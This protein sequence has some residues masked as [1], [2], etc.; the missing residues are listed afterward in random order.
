MMESVTVASD[1]PELGR[2]ARDILQ[3]SVRHLWHRN[4]QV[5]LYAD[6]GPHMLVEGH[7]AV[8]RDIH[9]KEYIDAAGRLLTSAVGYG[10]AEI[11]DAMA[12]QARRLHFCETAEGH[13]NLPATLL[14]AKLAEIAPGNLDVTFFANSGTEANETA[15]KMAIQCQALRG[16]PLRRKVISRNWSYHGA[17]L[18]SLSVNGIVWERFRHE[19]LAPGGH[20]ITQP[21]CYR[22]ELGL[23]YPACEV[24]CAKML[25]N[26]I[27]MEGPDSVAAFI[28]EPISVPQA[29]KV[30]PPEYWP[31]IRDICSRYDVLLIVDEVI[32]GFGRTGKMFCS[33]HWDLEPDIMTCAKGITSGYI[34]LGS[35][36]A[37]REV[38]DTFWGDEDDQ[39]IHFC[40]YSGHSVSCAAALANLAIIEREDLVGHSR[41]MGA[42]LLDGLR[43]FEDRP[44]VGNVSGLGLLVSVELVADRTTKRPISKDMSDYLENRFKSMGLLA[45]VSGGSTVYLSPP[46]VI[47]PEQVD[48]VVDIVGRGLA[49]LAGRFD[50]A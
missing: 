33:E 43:E 14:A 18:G 42:R 3:E 30:P 49:D 21:Y 11:A 50:L 25:E 13:T 46:L 47:E 28:A 32:C 15:M 31:T 6:V 10:R 40:T 23:T 37:T 4:T 19:P 48:S 8:V 35:A 44:L 16:H 9:G 7:G 26:Q 34:P 45:R 36:T 27:L 38:A 20:F 41:E 5:A 12:T 29:V 24:Q 2:R 17:T 22:C 39:F 1:L